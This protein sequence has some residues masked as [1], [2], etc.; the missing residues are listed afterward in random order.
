MCPARCPPDCISSIGSV[1]LN[2]DGVYLAAGASGKGLGS[3]P[4]IAM[5]YH[6]HEL[7]PAELL[8]RYLDLGLYAAD[9]SV[10]FTHSSNL[11]RALD[12]AVRCL[13]RRLSIAAGDAERLRARLRQCGFQ[14]LAADEAASPAVTTIVLPL[15]VDS[16]ALGAEV[17]RAGYLISCRS[18]YLRTRNWVQICLMGKYRRDRMDHLV[19][20]LRAARDRSAAGTA[21]A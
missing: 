17:E 6:H 8:P 2:L 10:P 20:T 12:A 16:A 5:V 7:Q 15:A 14:I 1:P 11:I 18:G 9:D 13:D 4:G 3:L 21:M 19:D